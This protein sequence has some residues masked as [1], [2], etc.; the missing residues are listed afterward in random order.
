MRHY[1][2]DAQGAVR[3]VREAGGVPV[4]AH[5]LAARRGRVVTDAVIAALAAAGLAG[6]EV[7]HRDHDPAEREHLRGLAAELDMLTTGASD[8]H[9]TGKLNRLGEN[10]TTAETLERIEAMATGSRVVRP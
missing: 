3:L 10:L 6:L 1:A 9:G 8:Y 5:P 4:M 7:D 2:P